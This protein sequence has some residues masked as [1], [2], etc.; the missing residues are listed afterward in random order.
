MRL[1]FNT[2]SYG[3]DGIVVASYQADWVLNPC[4]VPMRLSLVKPILMVKRNGILDNILKIAWRK[5][6][7]KTQLLLKPKLFLNLVLI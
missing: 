2:R 5:E 4:L 3:S 7:E 1:H 6:L